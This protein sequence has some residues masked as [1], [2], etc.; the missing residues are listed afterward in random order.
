MS[1]YRKD[2]KLEELNLTIYYKNNEKDIMS[3]IS[4]NL[5]SINEV[6]LHKLFNIST[7]FNLILGFVSECFKKIVQ[8][9]NLHYVRENIRNCQ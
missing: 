5:P 4:K 8:Y 2:E 7:K 6:F 9:N 3:S 1:Y